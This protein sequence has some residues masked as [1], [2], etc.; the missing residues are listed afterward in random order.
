MFVAMTRFGAIDGAR[1][2]HNG[3]NQYLPLEMSKSGGV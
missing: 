1:T 3:E 2:P